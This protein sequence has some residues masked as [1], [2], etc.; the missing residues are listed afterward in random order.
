MTGTSASRAV[1]R[2]RGR[3]FLGAVALVTLTVA[4]DALPQPLQQAARPKTLVFRRV[5]EPKE[6]AFSVLVPQGW[7]V[8]GGVFRINPLTA[9]G[10][11]NSMW[12]KCDLSLKRDRSGSTMIRFLPTMNYADFSHPRFAIQKQLFPP[13]SKFQGGLVKPMPSVQEFLGELFQSVHPGVTEVRIQYR[14]LPE[15]A[16]IVN[17]VHKSANDMFALLKMP[18]M[19]A[20]AGVLLAEYREG[21][22]LYKEALITALVDARGA[23][24]YWCNSETILMRAPAAEVKQWQP[25]MDV[26]CQ[27][28]RPNP[29]WFNLEIAK[30]DRTSRILAEAGAKIR[31]ENLQ[32]WQQRQKIMDRIDT[33]WML[34]RT[35]QAKYSNP[36]TGATE[37]DTNAWNYRWVTRLGDVIYT[38]DSNYNPNSDSSLWSNE[39]QKTPVTG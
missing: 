11:F 36:Y 12:P 34:Y 9:G 8:E 31:E 16:D 27:S 17:R 33:D 13:G 1:S 22:V 10:P 2:W 39:W 32:L 7:I 26:I 14:A 23:A 15:L 18:P 6:N 25:V 19:L 37:L 3:S 20:S 29:V 35:G 21:G 5:S 4:P 28:L 30:L 38:D 24:V